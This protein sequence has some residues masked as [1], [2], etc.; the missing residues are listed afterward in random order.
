MVVRQGVGQNPHQGLVQVVELTEVGE[1]PCCTWPVLR[2][3]S[4]T[5]SR[6]TRHMPHW[7]LSFE[8]HLGIANFMLCVLFFSAPRR[9]GPEVDQRVQPRFTHEGRAV[10]A[11]RSHSFFLLCIKRPFSCSRGR[12]RRWGWGAAGGHTVITTQPAGFNKCSLKRV[13][14]SS[15]PFKS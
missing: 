13:F 5:P 11:P 4:W 15:C 10:V 6:D 1:A 14:R 2:C 8:S 12:S 3:V 7:R 9:H